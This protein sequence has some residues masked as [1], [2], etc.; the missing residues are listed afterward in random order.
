MPNE[1]LYTRRKFFEFSSLALLSACTDR[2]RQ[3]D[4][5]ASLTPGW[6]TDFEAFAQDLV[7]TNRIPGLTLSIAQHGRVLYEKAF[8]YR[9]VERSIAA[10]P[11][12][13]F[14]LGSVSKNFTALAIMQ[15][16]DAGKLWVAN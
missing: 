9:D 12:T 1:T 5:R 10:T 7:T 8:G 2:V 11:E 14:G 15:L 4:G 6:L 16:Q 13:V 3:I